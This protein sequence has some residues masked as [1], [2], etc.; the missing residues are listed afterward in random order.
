MASV[1][2]PAQLS[3]M[4]YTACCSSM[5][6][7]VD[8]DAGEVCRGLWVGSLSA[9]EDA[10]ALTSHGITHVVTVAARLHPAVPPT[11]QHTTIALDD[12]PCADLLGKLAP[13]LEAIDAGLAAAESGSDGGGVLVHCAS[14]VSRSCATCVAW[15]M[16]RRGLSLDDALAQVRQCRPTANPNLGFKAGLQILEAEG[17]NMEAAASRW[18]ATHRE[19]LLERVRELRE[20]ANNFHARSDELEERVAQRRSQSGSTTLSSELRDALEALQREIDDAA[21]QTELDDRVA[22]SIRRAAV[23]KIDRLLGE[24]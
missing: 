3:L 15:L 19:D 20:S 12:H 8:W 10:A 9:A 24:A 14:G 1:A 2:P 13:A 17:G 23:Q 11:A 6:G 7:T 22:R 5:E 16:L 4:R 21:P 18:Q